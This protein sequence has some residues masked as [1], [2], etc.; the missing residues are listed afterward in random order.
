MAQVIG[1]VEDIVF[2][3][4]DNGFSVVDIREEGTNQII[5]A[6]GSFPYINQGERVMVEGEWTTH[7][8]YGQQIKMVTYSSVAPSSLVGMES[9]LASG[10]IKGV[11][12]STARALVR[13]FGLDVLDI[14]QFNPQR[15]T[16]V[17]G[18]GKTRAEMIA[19]SFIEQ[20]DIR[21]AMIFLQ[22]Y[23][24]TT[25]YALKIY[26]AYGANTI[27]VVRENPYRLAEDITG[28]GFKT[29]DRIARSLG[30][31]MNSPFRIHSFAVLNPCSSR[32]FCQV[33]YLTLPE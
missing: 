7:P 30:I 3:N 27:N 24:I 23:G 17:D 9:Y 20:K 18:I 11:G 22:S 26:K 4:E 13:H 12:P 31:D 21:E 32:Y 14:I 19:S 8:D 33:S 16:E 5:T 28:I 29:A 1:I 25:S 2:R 15:L 10:L 6:V